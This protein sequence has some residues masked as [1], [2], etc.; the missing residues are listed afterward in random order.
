MVRVRS[1]SCAAI[2]R[3][4]FYCYP[5]L[6]LLGSVGVGP[7]ASIKLFTCVYYCRT[8]YKAV[9]RGDGDSGGHV[10]ERLRAEACVD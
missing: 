3:G 7:Q 5:V 9:C 2:S 10:H 1:P 8:Y 4:I 6:D